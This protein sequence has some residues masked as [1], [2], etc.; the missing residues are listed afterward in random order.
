MP[1]AVVLM[2][3]RDRMLVETRSQVLRTAGYTVVTAYT[4]LQA[5][6]QFLR[7]NF[8]V[9]LLCHSIP[10]D[11][12]EHLAK[13][14]RQQKSRIPIVCVACV[15]GQFDGFA[16]AT[17]ENDPKALIHSL[18]YVLYRGRNK[19]DGR[20]QPTGLNPPQ[21][22]SIKSKKSGGEKAAL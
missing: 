12:R 14:L 16:D 9:V 13:V 3:G 8:D 10:A 5:I 1:H 6:D 4:P 2:I 21:R 11:G 20:Q 18:R 17:I 19:S 22:V 15:D 7:G